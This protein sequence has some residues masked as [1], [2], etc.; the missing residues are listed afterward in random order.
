M[1]D[2][3]GIVESR[4]RVARSWVA[5]VVVMRRQGRITAAVA[6]VTLLS[7]LVTGCAPWLA[8]NP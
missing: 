7:G 8:A 3:P 1:C 6:V 2:T 5:T 4:E